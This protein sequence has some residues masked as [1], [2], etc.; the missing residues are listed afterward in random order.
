[1]ETNYY[2]Y[3]GVLY[4]EPPFESFK[5]VNADYRDDGT[6]IYNIKSKRPS[7]LNLFLLLPVIGLILFNVAVYDM[8]TGDGFTHITRIPEQM[9]YDSVSGTI[10]VDIENDAQ[11][12]GN[13][14]LKLV[15]DLNG[16]T[17]LE[18]EGIEPG[19]SIG[20]IPVESVETGMPVMCTLYYTVTPAYV[21]LTP[22]EKKVMLIDRANS[23]SELNQYF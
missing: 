13:I 17:L 23:D 7:I 2:R 14:S 16:Q 8:R 15:D 5:V 3:K 22:L 21:S 20:S 1:M 19:E 10:D 6:I 4:E 9:Y 18:L 11:N 12:V